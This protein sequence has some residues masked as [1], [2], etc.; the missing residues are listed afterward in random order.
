MG[1]WKLNLEALKLNLGGGGVPLAGD[2]LVV[3][4]GKNR[5]A[6]DTIEKAT[7]RSVGFVVG[8]PLITGTSIQNGDC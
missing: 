7:A 3:E 4:I 2:F 1:A 6:I 5:S 8:I